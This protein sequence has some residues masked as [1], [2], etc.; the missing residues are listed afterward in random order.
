MAER[1]LLYVNLFGAPDIHRKMETGAHN[2]QDETVHNTHT[3]DTTAVTH[4][5][6]AAAVKLTFVS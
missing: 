2:R 4:A 1:P 3:A 6:T 5:S